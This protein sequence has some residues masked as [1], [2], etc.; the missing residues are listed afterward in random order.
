MSFFENLTHPLTPVASGS[1][2]SFLHAIGGQGQPSGHPLGLAKRD[3][4]VPCQVAWRGQWISS[5]GRVGV[6]E[7][8]NS[9]PF[10][11]FLLQFL[12]LKKV[13]ASKSLCDLH[14]IRAGIIFK[15]IPF[16]TRFYRQTKHCKCMQ[17]IIM[18][19]YIIV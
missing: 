3:T 16:N 1:T 7:A 6:V 5:L 2:P 9:E 11:C 18:T 17:K 19:F 10:P 14:S 4:A 8:R 13:C 15:E 12:S